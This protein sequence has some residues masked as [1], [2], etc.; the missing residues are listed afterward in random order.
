VADLWIAPENVWV[1]FV[2]R[3]SDSKYYMWD[4]DI[5]KLFDSNVVVKIV[6]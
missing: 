6:K 1:P 5:I 3:K 4:W 2:V